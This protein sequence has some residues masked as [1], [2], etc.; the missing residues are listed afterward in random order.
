[1]LMLICECPDTAIRLHK[2]R[3]K[4]QRPVT[5]PTSRLHHHAKIQMDNEKHRLKCS[6]ENLSDQL[7]KQNLEKMAFRENNFKTVKTIESE[8]FFCKS[9]LVQ[10]S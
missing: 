2:Y 6:E 8:K 10:R 4:G 3:N 9:K 7:I 5:P 1:M